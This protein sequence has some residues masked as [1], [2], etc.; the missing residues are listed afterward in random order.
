MDT[1]LLTPEQVA[2][3]LQITLNTIYVWLRSGRLPGVRMGH[4]WRVR[5]EA[6]EAFLEEGERREPKGAGVPATASLFDLA[7]EVSARIPAD[8]WRDH[9]TDGSVNHDRY[10][11]GGADR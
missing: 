7:D 9:R 2:E 8:A 10:L 3:R 6:L 11:R 4:R 5:P 1:P